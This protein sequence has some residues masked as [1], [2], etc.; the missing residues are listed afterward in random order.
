MTRKLREEDAEIIR[1]GGGINSRASEDQIDPLE[2]TT[3]ENFVLDPGNSEFR[4]RAP[5][6]LIG[7]VPNEAEI[8][9]FATLTK[10]D[11][12]TSM[13]VQAGDTVYSW[14]GVTTFTSK[15]TVVATARLRGPIEANW[16]LS[17]KVIITDLA[18]DE[19][20]HVWDGTTLSEVTFLQ[21]DGSTG[22]GEFRAKYCI[23]ENERAIFGNILESST[24]FPHL[25]VGSERG[26]Y[27]IISASD[28][29]SS[30]LSEQDPWFLPTPQLK[31]I[32]GLAAVFNIIAISQ[33]DGAFEKLTGSTA[34][35]FNIEKFFRGSGAVG[36]EAVVATSNDVIYGARGK[37]ESLS[38]VEQ[39]GDVEVD[40]LSF[41]IEP[42]V[43]SFKNWTLVYNPRV[44]RV[45]CFPD[46]A[47]QAEIWV[48]HTDFIGSDLSPWSK[49]TTLHAL[50]FSPTAVM[51]CRDPADGLEY[52]F[53]GDASGNLYRLEGSGAD[54]DGGTAEILAF[55]KSRVI[56][57]GLDT[58]AF[59]IN[60]WLQHRKKL[61]ND[62]VLSFDFSGEHVHQVD[63]TID[64]SALSTINITVYGGD[65]YYGGTFYYGPSQEDRLVRRT[66][67]V[68]AMS[69]QFQV[70]TRIQGTNEFS[71]TE[72]GFRFDQAS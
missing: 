29:P 40:D 28:R 15:G 52:T 44:K 39:F 12:T 26:D 36:D 38:A 61:A 21:N 25:L 47:N 46:I 16:A 51:V 48:L 2:C 55:R 13:L 57:S 4:R 7:T 1:F 34:K 70:E 58:K 18:L 37:I 30:S 66:F 67:G 8:R 22:F 42:D 24:E 54:G 60:G 62:V 45:Y 3:G 10:T 65:V 27:T 35:D 19:E 43:R 68:A 23:V 6:D 14:D 49:W 63:K 33:S 9:G 32:N 11:G 69:N 72:I 59:H 50:N 17:D 41:K 56:Q 20:V 53:M 71:I 31:P 5:F 64:L